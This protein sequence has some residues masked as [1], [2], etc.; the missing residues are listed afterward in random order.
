VREEGS[1]AQVNEDGDH[2]LVDSSE[3]IWTHVIP[4]TKQFLDE[5]EKEIK[6]RSADVDV[7]AA[8]YI[9]AQRRLGTICEELCFVGSLDRRG[10]ERHP[11]DNRHQ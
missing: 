1:G 4:I 9:S 6:A 5:Y 8:V 3:E 11:Q 10:D 7:V 2:S